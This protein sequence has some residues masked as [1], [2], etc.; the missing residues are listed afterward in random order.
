MVLARL[1]SEV[2]PLVGLQVLPLLVSQEPGPLRVGL[3]AGPGPRLRPHQ[4][5]QLERVRVSRLLVLLDLLL[6]RLD[7]FQVAVP[8]GLRHLRAALVTREA[9]LGI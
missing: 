9:G 8:V 7:M 5:R 3:Q 1:R 4:K 6:A 2:S